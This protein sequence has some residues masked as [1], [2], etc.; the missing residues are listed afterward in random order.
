MKTWKHGDMDMET[1]HGDMEV[2]YWGIL[3]F[4]E[5]KIKRETGSENP[6]NFCLPFAHRVNRSLSLPKKQ[7]KVICLQTD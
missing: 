3:A 7:T 5:K 1:R 6:G 2:K 4:Y